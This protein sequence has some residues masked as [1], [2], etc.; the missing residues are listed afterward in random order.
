VKGEEVAE[1]FS[2]YESLP[3]LTRARRAR[4]MAFFAVI[5]FLSVGGFCM[6]SYWE[7]YLTFYIPFPALSFSFVTFLIPGFRVKSTRF[8][9]CKSEQ[10]V[11][12]DILR[13]DIPVS[14]VRSRRPPVIVGCLRI[15]HS[16][17]SVQIPPTNP[18]STNNQTRRNLLKMPLH[19][20]PRRDSWPPTQVY[21]SPSTTT[22]TRQ[23]LQTAIDENPFAFFLTSPD[24]IDI[25]DYLSD[26]DLNAG[27]ETPDSSRSPVREVSPSALQR[28]P[29]PL[30]HHDEDEIEIHDDDEEYEFGFGMAIPL[31]LKEFTRNTL[32]GRKSRTSHYRENENENE[33]EIKGLGISNLPD[34]SGRGR[35]RVKL[36]PIRGRGRGSRSLSAR[37]PASWRAPSPEIFSIR[38]ERE[39]DEEKEKGRLDGLGGVGDEEVYSVSAPAS[40]RVGQ[41]GLASPGLRVKEK[42]KKRVHWAL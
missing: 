2:T 23:E 5:I 20:L 22:T 8:F 10:T 33:K 16:F 36:V 41:G 30:N 13:G 4:R 17:T 40:S 11:A 9:L 26:D 35:A 31:T 14:A 24:E 39:S 37:R 42:A 32:S 12:F 18:T 3:T 38:E 7:S 29:L 28:N 1:T 27:I 25:D 15:T 6:T 19:S 34:F 21:L